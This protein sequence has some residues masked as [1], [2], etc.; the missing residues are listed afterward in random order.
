MEKHAE[1]GRTKSPVQLLF[2]R[3]QLTSLPTL[4]QHHAAV[5]LDEAA[6]SKDKVFEKAKVYHNQGKRAL[7]VL[8]V[9]MP[10]IMQSS[11]TGLWYRP[12]V[13]TK[14]RQGGGSYCVKDRD[15]RSFVRARRFLK[16]IEAKYQTQSQLKST[17]P[18]T[19]RD[20]KAKNSP[21]QK[22]GAA[23]RRSKC[24]QDKSGSSKEETKSGN[25]LDGKSRTAQVHL[26]NQVPSETVK[27]WVNQTPN[28]RLPNS[29]SWAAVAAK[30]RPQPQNLSLIHI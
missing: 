4:P 8:R 24:L 14:V 7:P 10:V 6:A 25:S 17:S 21:S 22:V 27:T 28:P 12:C 20:V 11:A 1:S 9:G 5:D 19:S 18:S 13:I 30:S 3:R 23:P 26:K 29:P 15:G 2:G 16:E